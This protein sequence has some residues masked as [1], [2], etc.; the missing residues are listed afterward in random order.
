MLGL[1]YKTHFA[2]LCL[3]LNLEQYLDVYPTQLLYSCV[4]DKDHHEEESS[5]FKIYYTV[6][7]ITNTQC[8]N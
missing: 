3:F 4:S 7:A 8:S 5:T 2:R 6:V 1:L